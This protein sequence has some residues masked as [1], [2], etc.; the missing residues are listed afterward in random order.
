MYVGRMNVV[1]LDLAVRLESVRFKLFMAKGVEIVS[2]GGNRDSLFFFAFDLTLLK[3]LFMHLQQHMKKMVIKA[4]DRDPTDVVI[5]GFPT[6]AFK[7]RVGRKRM[8][9][10]NVN[11]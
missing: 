10:L 6:Q 5:I 9:S 7:N 3:L 2:R 4:V 8:S 11:L 1:C